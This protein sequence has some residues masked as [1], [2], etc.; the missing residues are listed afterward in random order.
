MPAEA[1]NAKRAVLPS[2]VFSFEECRT[3][4]L[5]RNDTLK[6]TFNHNIFGMNEV[7]VVSVCV[8]Q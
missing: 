2:G 1:L 8:L 6:Y 5:S 4:D 7:I 3:V